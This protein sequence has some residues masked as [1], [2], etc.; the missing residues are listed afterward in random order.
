MRRELLALTNALVVA[1]AIAGCGAA[2]SPDKRT[3]PVTEVRPAPPSTSP[4]EAVGVRPVPGQRYQLCTDPVASRE[5]LTSPWTYHALA[6]GSK[7]Y[8]VSQYE[9]LPGYGKALPPLPSYISSE[10]G[11]TQAAVV[12]APGAPVELPAYYFPG[13]PILYFFEGGPYGPIGLQSVSGD[14]FIGGSAPGYPEPAFDD[15][16]SAAGIEAQNDTDDFSGGSSTLAAGA[17]A[18]ATTLTTT[19]AIGG[20]IGWAYFADGTS[21]A[22][23]SHS[24][25]TI[26]L[27]SPL[28]RAEGEGATVWAN[29]IPAIGQVTAPAPQGATR[30]E[31]RSSV[32]LV[33]YGHVV[34]GADSY[35]LASVSGSPSAYTIALTGGLDFPVTI[36]TPVFYNGPA[37]DVTVSYLEISHDL[38]S[39]TGT[40]YMGDGWTVSHDYIHDSYAS[41]GLGVAIYGGGNTTIE[42]DCLSRMGDYGVNL[43][44]R[45]DKFDYSEIYESNYRPDP[46]CGCSG[47]GKWWGTLNADIVDDAFVDDSPAGGAPVWLDNGNSGTLIKGNYFYKSYGSAV[48]SETGYDLDVTG[49]LFLDDGWGKG[50]GGCGSNCDGAL[51]LNSSGGFYV[52]GSRYEGRVVVSGNQ[53][54]DDWMG[55]DIWQSGAR[56]CENS[57][58]GWPNDS[59]YCSG[60]FPNSASPRAGGRYYFSHEGDTA[61][62]GA[63]SL[64]EPAQA[65]SSTLLVTGAVAIDDQV[66]FGDPAS[67]T[68]SDR[69]DV[70]ALG[71]SAVVQVATTRGFPSSG[72]L[73]V[74]T[75]SAWAD[76][77]GSY[78]GAIL[79]YTGATSTSFTGVSL[80]RGSGS[81]A[82][83]V[84]EVQPYT[85]E[86][87]TC[88]ANDCALEVSPP[89]G[90]AEPAGTE[91]SNAG[92]CQL[93][94]TSS[95]T[96][97]Q[98][99][100]PDG[101][102]YWE[103]CQ[104]GATHI[105]VTANEFVFRPAVIAAGRPLAGGA[106]ATACTS[107]QAG[108]CG[109]NFMAYQDAGE[110]PFSSQVGA[111]MIMRENT[112]S[113]NTYSGPWRWNAYLYG[114]CSGS[115]SLNLSGWRSVWHQD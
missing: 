28:R 46:G 23:A 71:G 30:V 79:S 17:S 56:S 49:N 42:Y 34:I 95:A 80:L 39:T 109:T 44:G 103:G 75:S 98:P 72:E 22:I 20:Y 38:H 53:F 102:S 65:G 74:G 8:T 97:S 54:V 11:T 66:G 88:Y 26:T 59:A 106:N 25:T 5:Y 89:L 113:A 115:C 107:G 19:S 35:E 24:G 104:W 68:T 86:G 10:P 69:E 101:V 15:R 2:A 90:Q 105:S 43:F 18:G 47:G 99:V 4:A 52:P 16:G 82:G 73:R 111:N 62:G 108:F 50:A 13:S 112:W 96:P 21:Y 31:V 63:T 45:N 100:A 55:I 29:R 36:G 33:R 41:P 40:I 12:F 76:G 67:T 81:L 93:Y 60:G 114:G 84:V 78:T 3:A 37:G 70:S 48:T 77:G 83:P 14:V 87:E 27:R 61:H 32:P 94:A 57:G 1:G 91:V 58:E 110:A 7:S 6:S 64:A 85:V 51:N 9:A 92:T